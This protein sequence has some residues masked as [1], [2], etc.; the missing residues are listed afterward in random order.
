MSAVSGVLRRY[1]LREKEATQLL[2]DLSQKLKIDAKK[3]L[4]PK[5][6]IE[7]AETPAAEIFVVNGKPLLARSGGVLFPTLIFEGIFPF[8]PKVVVDMGAVSHVCNGADVMAPGV[9]RIEGSFDESD[10]LLILDE[11]YGKSLAI[12]ATLFN[13]QT[14]RTLKRGKIA[15]TIH[16]VGD[17]LWGHIK[18]FA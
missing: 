2:T 6:R 9:V 15:K 8:L 10:L 11:R 16:H 13:S 18:M 12:G 3:L 4:G 17:K 7:R 5:P 14:M 1:F